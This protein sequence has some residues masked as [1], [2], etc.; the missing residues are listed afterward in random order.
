LEPSSH[1]IFQ[2]ELSDKVT[3]VH[4]QRRLEILRS[5]NIK[6]NPDPQKVGYPEVVIE[7]EL[8]AGRKA[9]V[10]LDHL[11][12][13]ATIERHLRSREASPYPPFHI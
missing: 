13:L 4:L 6:R 12:R 3:S 2:N 5:Q 1:L 7:G 8:D 11:S 10:S 9:A